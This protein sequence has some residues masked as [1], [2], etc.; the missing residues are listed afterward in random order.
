[1]GQKF[2][3]AKIFLHVV[4]PKAGASMENTSSIISVSF[5]FKQSQP[6]I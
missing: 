4:T 2:Y 6:L 3:F 5:H 1:M